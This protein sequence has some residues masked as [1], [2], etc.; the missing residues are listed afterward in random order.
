[1]AT[2]N[3]AE[4]G[5]WDDFNDDEKGNGS[6]TDRPKTPYLDTSK[7]GTYKFRPVGP[8]IK[9]RKSFKPYRATLSDKD[10]ETDPAAKAGWY[11]PRR[12]AINV[13]DRAD[14]E[15]KVLEKG[16]SVFK[17]FSNYKTVFQKNPSDIKEGADFVLT[18][19]IP[20][21]NGQPNKIKTEYTVTHVGTTPLTEAEIEKIKKQ[22]LYPLTE[23]YK[24]TPLEKRIEMWNALPEA[25]KIPP[26][27][28]GFENAKDTKDSG[29]AA[30]APVEAK[31]VAAV[32]ETMKNSPADTDDDLF[33]D[34][35]GE[36]DNSTSKF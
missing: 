20:K 6:T 1:M 9:C 16:A 2:P 4:K 27:K 19:K 24:S 10:L 17:G 13:I 18:V 33:A 5:N 8:Y 31:P 7:A 26:K 11:L 14:G 12:Y 22:R 34:A 35:S 23:I 29:D 3:A 25:S 30:A 36:G 28:E 15:L 32:E 21:I